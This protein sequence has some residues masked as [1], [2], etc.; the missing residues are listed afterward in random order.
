MSY[1]LTFTS[2]TR[3]LPVNLLIP[4][5]IHQVWVLPIPGYKD[6]VRHIA[7]LYLS[8]L[9]ANPLEVIEATSIGKLDYSP[10]PDLKFTT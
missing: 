1:L 5:L 2:E 8:A 6:G 7:T 3:L 10:G 9:A 4:G